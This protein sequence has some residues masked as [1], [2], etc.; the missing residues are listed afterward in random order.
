MKPY[1]NINVTADEIVRVF[2]EDIDEIELQWHRDK[3]DRLVEAI[4][5]TDWMIQLDNDLPVKIESVK[6]P[7]G[8]WHRVIKGNNDLKIRITYLSISV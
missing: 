3:E 6:I 1:T 4:E 2:S 8:Q 7:A 5:P